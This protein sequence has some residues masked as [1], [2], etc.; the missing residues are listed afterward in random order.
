MYVQR[1]CWREKVNLYG[2]ESC[3]TQKL[4]QPFL[5]RFLFF[6]RALHT[7]FTSRHVVGTYIS[8]EAVADDPE[9]KHRRVHII[10]SRFGRSLGTYRCVFVC[11]TL[12]AVCSTHTHT[13][14][15]T[16]GPPTPL[17]IQYIYIY[18]LYYDQRVL[19]EVCN[20]WRSPRVSNRTLWAR[21]TLRLAGERWTVG[22]TKS[23][24]VWAA[25]DSR[26]VPD[27]RCRK[28]R[29]VG[30]APRP[31]FPTKLR[32][33]PTCRELQKQKKNKLVKNTFYKNFLSI[34][35]CMLRSYNRYYI[36]FEVGIREMGIDAPSTMG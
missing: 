26:T 4:L 24:A 16:H 12:F 22:P 30:W 27:W 19:P 33:S 1:V 7:T 9:N 29:S 20:L 18:M 13:H 28:P 15:Y 6:P 10:G 3:I 32:R 25:P 21:P 34:Y 14:T 5:V 17:V 23:W 31:R 36:M 2:H 8:T 35:S 11:L